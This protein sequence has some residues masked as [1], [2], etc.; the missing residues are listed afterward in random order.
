MTI[1]DKAKEVLA[2]EIAALER[3]SARLDENFINAVELIAKT[4]GSINRHSE[5]VSA[6]LV[7]TTDAEINS[8]RREKNSRETGKIIVSGVGKS[9]IIGQ[10]IA[11][12]FSSIGVSAVFLHPVEALHG[13]IGM[14]QKDDAVILLSK[15][16]NTEELTRLIPFLK[17]RSAKIIAITGNPTSFLAT[18]AD[19][20]L[21]AS[22][23]KE[24]CPF[25][26]AP[27]ASTTVALAIGD[28][29]AVCLMQEMG[30]TL[31]DF[32]RLHPLGQIGRTTNL[33][34]KD[35]MQRDIAIASVDTVFK[36]ALILMSQKSFGCI[37]VVEK[38]MVND[39][40]VNDDKGEQTSPL[41]TCKD[42]ISISTVGAG[43]ACPT[44]DINH[45]KL[46]GILTDGDVRRVLSNYDNVLEMKLK[47]LMTVNPVTVRQDAPLVE[48]LALMENRVNQISVLPVVADGIL[49]GLIRIHDILKG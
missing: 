5:L 44:T 32:S 9:G 42:A 21:D 6:S 20:S 30:F 47:D 28:A 34:V 19:I 3:L 39:K 15:S 48:A 22:V 45:Y 12:T 40:M 7:I 17:M 49:L 29:L 35:V 16:G 2:V 4:V 11:A 14:V 37:C 18:N 36:D 46:L 13:D 41:Q 24:A 23:E 26:L 1:I 27:T 25:N 10:K 33:T 43:S 38:P 31:E 8:A